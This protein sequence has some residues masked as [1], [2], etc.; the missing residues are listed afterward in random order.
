MG[1]ASA[2]DFSYVR[3][4]TPYLLSTQIQHSTLCSSFVELEFASEASFVRFFVCLRVTFAASEP[5][6]AF[7]YAQG[8]LPDQYATAVHSAILPAEG[9]ALP[10]SFRMYVAFCL[11][12]AQRPL[13]GP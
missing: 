7:V 11:K 13:M 8:D 12:A 3:W 4:K 9:S 2:G 1:G 6:C 5:L 10:S